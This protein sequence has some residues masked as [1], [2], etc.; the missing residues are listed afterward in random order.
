MNRGAIAVFMFIVGFMAS[1]MLTETETRQAS[2]T[3]EDIPSPQLWVQQEDIFYDEEKLTLNIP[4]LIVAEV[5][6]TTNSMD[7]WIDNSFLIEKP[8]ED[9]TR[10]KVGDIITYP[11]NSTRVVHRIINMENGVIQTKGDNNPEPDPY[12]I[13]C[14]GINR[15][16]GILT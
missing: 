2:G 15:V 1:T 10:L 7:P 8:I 16:I 6:P 3:S 5:D 14:N 12:T 11:M 9:C 13:T 4:N